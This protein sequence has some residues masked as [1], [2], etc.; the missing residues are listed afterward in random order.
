MTSVAPTIVGMCEMSNVAYARSQ[1][2]TKIQS[3]GPNDDV[4]Y[5][6]T[7]FP[8]LCW[9]KCNLRWSNKWVVYVN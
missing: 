4:Q 5:D 3:S 6:V 9:A 7:Y 2:F 1:P 8:A